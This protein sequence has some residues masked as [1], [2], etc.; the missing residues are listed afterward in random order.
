MSRWRGSW[1]VIALLGCDP[2]PVPSGLAS[3]TFAL[4][5]A[6]LGPVSA[7]EIT[8]SPG[9]VQRWTAPL[10]DTIF[11]SLAPDQAVAL[12]V[13]ALDTDVERWRGSQQIPALR[14]GQRFAAE[15]VVDAVGRLELE[16]PSGWAVGVDAPTIALR[17]GSNAV[18]LP[19][20][21]YG[22]W[23]GVPPDPVEGVVLEIRQGEITRFELPD[24]VPAEELCNGL[25]DNCDG[26]I[27]EGVTNV[28][29]GCG[30]VPEELCNGLD[31]NCD[32]Q[33][34]EGV[35]NACGGCGPVPD[36]GC[37]PCDSAVED[38]RVYQ[39]CAHA[40]AAGATRDGP[41]WLDR[42]GVS[43]PTWCDQ[44]VAGGGWT[45]IGSTDGSPSDEAGAWHQDLTTTVPEDDEPRL[46]GTL[47]AFPA[48]VELR[49]ACRAEAAADPHAPFDVDLVVISDDLHAGITD[50]VQACVL[51]YQM[52][53]WDVLGDRRAQGAYRVEPACDSPEHFGLSLDGQIGD[54]PDSTAWG[55]WDS[56]RYCG[57]ASGRGLAGQWLVYARERR[58]SGRI[59]L[60]SPGGAAPEL[61][62]L[63]LEPIEADALSRYDYDGVWLHGD[64]PAW[65]GA[66]DDVLAAVTAFSD[67]HGQII[68]TDAAVSM[69][70]VRPGVEALPALAWFDVARL[71]TPEG[72]AGLV[73]AERNGVV[74]PLW[75]P[76]GAYSP[77][78]AVA[79]LVSA[80]RIG[81]T[82]APVAL[83]ADADGAPLGLSVVARG[84]R[85]GAS[86]LLAGLPTAGPI[87]A[88]MLSALLE[89]IDQPVPAWLP[90]VCPA[91]PQKAHL[92]GDFVGPVPLPV[93]MVAEARCD[94]TDAPDALVLGTGA[95]P[96]LPELAAYVEAGGRIVGSSKHSPA[97][98]EAVFGDVAAVGRRSGTCELGEL[99]PA[100]RLNLSHWFWRY[101]G[102]TL[103]DG[104]GCGA[105]ISGWPGLVALGGWGQGTVSIAYR[106]RGA[107][108]VWF[109]DVDWPD[110][111]ALS[112]ESQGLLRFMLGH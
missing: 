29:G 23:A 88:P 16:A 40:L 34:D 35:L 8:V 1:L 15:I 76:L 99:G 36:V 55:V 54:A 87:V 102:Q 39:S 72:T 44:T 71:P 59:A 57:L 65:I 60:L 61:E 42:D 84:R 32:G 18:I 80:L 3:V 92:C 95:L 85:C 51:A 101:N 49:F 66:G 5:E 90:D 43:Q 11:V 27:D 53:V 28:C 69:L 13:V 19:V 89:G 48:G 73:P 37:E 12:E 112:A 2:A 26:Q 86:V 7:V 25:D 96:P 17:E 103:A 22:L 20:G 93:G 4:D 10:A 75:R 58:V 21:V 110:A 31:D 91:R 6:A 77:L 50:E 9:A 79:P 45:L 38:C 97:L 94:V 109:V 100:E 56:V 108:R 67:Q 46:W 62:A 74:D 98:L 68:A 78:G 64:A 106:D 105:D 63:G 83:P 41:R 111:P 104:L 30:A 52:D 82:L 24:C 70:A 14:P 47:G 81:P 107:G 33:I